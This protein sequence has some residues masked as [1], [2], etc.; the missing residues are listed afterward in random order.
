MNVDGCAVCFEFFAEFFVAAGVAAVAHGVVVTS[1]RAVKCLKPPKALGFVGGFG[2]VVW[3]V[4]WVC[5]GFFECS[6]GP[7][8]DA[9]EFVG[10]VVTFVS[11][12]DGVSS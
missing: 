3:L 5:F 4:C 10:Q 6:I 9:C 8:C 11:Q 1:R 2:G 7:D 12:D